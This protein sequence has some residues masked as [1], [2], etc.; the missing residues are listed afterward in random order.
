M[1]SVP[2][3]AKQT[4]ALL[5]AKPAPDL[6]ALFLTC[7]KIGLL[8]FGGG[9]SGWLYQEFVLRNGWISDE[10]FASSLAISQMLPGANVVNLVIC[11]GDELRGLAGSVACVLGFLVG[12][13]F[14][15]IAL[16]AVFDALP[17]VSMLEAASNGVAYAALGLLLVI[18]FKGV[19][20][21]MKFPP[22]LAV[23]AVVATAVGLLKL[24]LIPVVVVA[25]PISV[26]LAWRRS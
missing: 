10:D 16:S 9:L 15:V 14:A 12:P 7:L 2:G 6:G 22:G 11:M 4:P 23:I 5:S 13:F 3:P 26:A 25:A 8:S 24:P 17:D 18:C 19:Q 1:T 20:R 21:T